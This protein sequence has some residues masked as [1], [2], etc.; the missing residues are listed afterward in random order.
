MNSNIHLA[1]RV[2]RF[3]C[4]YI[5]SFKRVI[6]ERNWF[7]RTNNLNCSLSVLSSSLLSN[8]RELNLTMIVQIRTFDRRNGTFEEVYWV[9]Q[10]SIRVIRPS[11]Q[12]IRG[13]KRV[14]R[15]SSHSEVIFSKNQK[16]GIARG[17]SYY[18]YA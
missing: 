13:R 8:S 17:D 9:T 12:G 14:T 4:W 3:G 16:V 6:R 10:C 5:R 7:T 11:K 2:I 1:K 15:P 18:C